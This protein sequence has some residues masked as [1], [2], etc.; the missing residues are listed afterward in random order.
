MGLS[1]IF[2]TDTSRGRN[3]RNNHRT[4]ADCSKGQESGE[5]WSNNST[6][7]RAEHTVYFYKYS[8]KIKQNF[9]NRHVL[10]HRL[11]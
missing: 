6:L 9:P 1:K 7:K 3:A 2:P 11:C 10:A 8:R 4:H 5:D